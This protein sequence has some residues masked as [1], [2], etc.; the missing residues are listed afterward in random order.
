MAEKTRKPSAWM[1]K[2]LQ[3]GIKESYDGRERKQAAP[4]YPMQYTG[5]SLKLCPLLSR[6]G[7]SAEA[8]AVGCIGMNRF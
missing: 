6:R 8:F 5:P 7:V 4:C 1:D 2:C 3:D